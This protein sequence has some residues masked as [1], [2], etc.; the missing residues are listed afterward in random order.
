[1]ATSFA[2][3][4]ISLAGNSRLRFADGLD[5]NLRHLDQVVEAAARDRIPAGIDGSGCFDRF[6][7]D[8]AMTT[9]RI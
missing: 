4:V 9:K 7:A 3:V 2:K 8:P 1:M 5:H 6:E